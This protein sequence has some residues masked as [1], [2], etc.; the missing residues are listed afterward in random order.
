M[1][2]D[3]AIRLVIF[4]TKLI[5]K[6]YTFEDESWLQYAEALRFLLQMTEAAL[7]H[8]STPWD[9]EGESD[10]GALRCKDCKSAQKTSER[11]L[12]ECYRYHAQVLGDNFCSFCD[13]NKEE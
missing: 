6:G 13:N 11:N 5:Q 2:R 9:N 4:Q 8:P 7:E 1:N 10:D 12:Y 3:D